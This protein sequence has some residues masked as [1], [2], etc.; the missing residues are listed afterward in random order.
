MIARVAF[1]PH[2]PLLVP[3]LV[4]GAATETEALRQA[5]LRAARTLTEVAED[6]LVI[7]VDQAGPAT[8][9]PASRGT[10]AGFGVELEVDLGAG[11]GPADP[12][13]PV[14]ALVAGWL[15]A[16]AGARSAQVRLLPPDLSPAECHEMGTRLADGPARTGLFVL[17]DSS[18]RLT[19]RSPVPPDE[20]AP[21]F[22][23]AISGA[24]AGGDPAPLAALDPELAV[25]LWAHGRAAY[26]VAAAATAGRDWRAELLYSDCPYGVGYHVATWV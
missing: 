8:L 10:F 22:D 24:L 5:C 23:A 21:A 20:R 25:E 2:P 14:P 6:W 16:H 3:E 17:A 18:A 9:G 7:A 1:A 13:L 4:T 19:P 15:R 11:E 12:L 26:Q